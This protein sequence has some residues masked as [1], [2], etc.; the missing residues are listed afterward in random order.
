MNENI[1]Y[2]EIP[3]SQDGTK[4]IIYYAIESLPSG[5]SVETISELA[6]KEK[7]IPYV[8]RKGTPSY[9]FYPIFAETNK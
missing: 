1:K 8:E 2:L 6:K 5:M 9:V 7:K 3:D 4:V